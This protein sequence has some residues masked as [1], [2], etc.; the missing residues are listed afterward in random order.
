MKNH[1][2][3]LQNPLVRSALFLLFTLAYFNMIIPLRETIMI[4]VNTTIRENLPAHIFVE[5]EGKRAMNLGVSN[6][7]KI[8]KIRMSYGMNFFI[9]VLGLIIISAP[10]KYF[11]IEF[12]IQAVCGVIIF[13]TAYLGIVFLNHFLVISDLFSIYLLPLSSLIMV[14]LAFI[15]KKHAKEHVVHEG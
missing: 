10:R 6:T 2:R 12:I 5:E 14:I 8:Y 9:G 7:N 4:Q 13:I 15:E 1:L 3:K 11:W